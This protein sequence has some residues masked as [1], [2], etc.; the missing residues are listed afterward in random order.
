MAD[1]PDGLAQWAADHFDETADGL[2]IREEQREEIAELVRQAE[3]VARELQ[4]ADF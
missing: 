4:N 1:V 2:V 3:E